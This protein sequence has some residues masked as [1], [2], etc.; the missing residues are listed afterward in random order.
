MADFP[1]TDQELEVKALLREQL[2]EHLEALD[3]LVAN[4]V[5]ALNEMLRA[6]GMLIIAG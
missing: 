5:A 3:A 2:R 1:P 4:E 6:R